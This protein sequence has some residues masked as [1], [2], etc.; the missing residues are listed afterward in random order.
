MKRPTSSKLVFV[1][2][3][4][5]DPQAFWEEF[6]PTLESCLHR[7][8]SPEDL[9]GYLEI[10][11]DTHADEL[12]ELTAEKLR[13]L[14]QELETITFKRPRGVVDVNR[15]DFQRALRW[16][17]GER[18]RDNSDFEAFKAQ[19]KEEHAAFIGRLENEMEAGAELVFWHTM[20][21]FGEL[22]V[23]GHFK[24]YIDSF[25]S[26]KPGSKVDFL[27]GPK[28]EL[29]VHQTNTRL[30]SS[31]M[32]QFPEHEC[33]VNDPYGTGERFFATTEYQ[34]AKRS[35]N[36]NASCDIPKVMVDT[37]EKREK[38]AR[39]FVHGIMDYRTVDVSRTPAFQH[40]LG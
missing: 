28:N 11:R 29:G 9:L 21:P 4:D 13:D 8:D 32:E 25:M 17:W 24:A 38:M 23:P 22:A 12:M 3:H 34:L 14:G 40:A 1:S 5:G 15:W 27:L 10:A 35:P 7:D 2:P 19:M 30:F 18:A 31:L 16:I 39:R 37:P 36:M 33:A 6:G 26:S 20:N